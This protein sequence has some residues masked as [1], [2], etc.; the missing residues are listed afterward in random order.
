MYG[1]DRGSN[2]NT[3]YRLWCGHLVRAVYVDAAHAGSEVG[4]T[5]RPW[6]TFD[7]AVH[8]A[9]SGNDVVMKAGTYSAANTVYGK[10]MTVIAD[11]GTV[12]L[13]VP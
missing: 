5:Q 13:Q 8:D 12:W 6:N 1:S 7:E 2:D 11:G 4:T 10:P 9:F 3:D